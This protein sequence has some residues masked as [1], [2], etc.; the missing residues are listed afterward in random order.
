MDAAGPGLHWAGDNRRKRDL[1]PSRAARRRRILALSL[2]I[3]FF[4]QGARWE[5]RRSSLANNL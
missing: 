1:I 5:A 3:A 4:T 2:D